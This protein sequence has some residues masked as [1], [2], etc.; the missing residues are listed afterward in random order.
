[1][2]IPLT[3]GEAAL[4]DPEDYPALSE[5]KWHVM[6]RGYAA[7]AD[8]STGKRKMVLMHRQ[9]LG[10]VNAPYNV[11]GDHING[12]TLDNRRSNLRVA[13]SR[14]S[15][16]NKGSN[17]GNSQYKGVCW[18]KGI[19]RWTMTIR[20]NGVLHTKTFGSEIEAA[21]AYDR[22]ALEAFGEY[23]QPNFPLEQ[24]V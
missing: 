14:Q 23:A 15:S 7:R 20:I 17:T 19:R 22:A 6:S 18:H 12:D 16:Q 21:M 9:L 8:Y 1:M 2:E 24:F 13:T 4:V 10:I 3:K 5:F 11:Y